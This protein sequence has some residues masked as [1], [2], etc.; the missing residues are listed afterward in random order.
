MVL[1]FCT[2]CRI[3]LRQQ[4]R[5]YTNVF[6]YIRNNIHFIRLE[7]IYDCFLLSTYQITLKL[8]KLVLRLGYYNLLFQML[9]L[10]PKIAITKGT[11]LQAIKL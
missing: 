9:V 4:Y 7:R 2:R 6:L 11:T 10:N 5:L 8:L 3:L 1:Q